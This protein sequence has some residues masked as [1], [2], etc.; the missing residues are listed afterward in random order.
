VVWRVRKSSV[1]VG[2]VG[3]AYGREWTSELK[4]QRIPLQTKRS[5]RCPQCSHILAKPDPKSS[6]T[7]FKIKLLASNYLPSIELFRRP[8]L[9]IGSRISAIGAG[10]ASGLRRTA[11]SASGKSTGDPGGMPEDE[12]LRQGRSYLFEMAFT[13]PLY[14]PIEVSLE[15]AAPDTSSVTKAAT[16][17][18]AINLQAP[19][20]PIS[21]FAEAWEYED[22][23]G[24]DEGDDARTG[25][26]KRLAPGIVERKAN[27]TTVALELHVGRETVGPVK[28]RDLPRPSCVFYFT[29]AFTDAAAGSKGP[30]AGDL[31]VQLG[32]ECFAESGSKGRCPGVA[33]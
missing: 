28:V 17:P 9:T 10:T 4:P 6:S 22:D 27:R 24:E 13:N 18:W 25:A 19:S 30:C 26:K 23:E 33:Q 15:V 32:R 12:P 14:E 5:K 2:W 7:R 3:D 31:Y 29:D 8:P 16:A 21:A 11:R 1:D 20:F